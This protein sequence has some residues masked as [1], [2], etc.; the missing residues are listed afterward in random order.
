[1]FYTTYVVFSHDFYRYKAILENFTLMTKKLQCNA[2][3]LSLGFLMSIPEI[4]KIIVG[5]DNLDQL[6]QIVKVSTIIDYKSMSNLACNDINLI[7]P[8]EWS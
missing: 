7:D 2:L 4:S 8:R 6:N 1:M 5:V 3:E